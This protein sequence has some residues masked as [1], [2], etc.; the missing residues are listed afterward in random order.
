MSVATTVPTS[1]PDTPR[2]LFA[3]Q[4]IVDRR[5]RLAGYELLY[6]GPRGADGEIPDA[7][8]ATCSVLVGAF[9]EVGFGAAVGRSTAFLNVTERFLREVDPLPLAPESTVL[10]LLEDARPTPELVSRLKALRAQ[11]FRVALD[12][13]APGPASTPLLEVADIVK[14]DLRA[15]PRGD[16]EKLM[17]SLTARGLTV[18]AEKVEDQSEF[19]WSGAAGAQLFQGYFFCKPEIVQ[20][21]EIPTSVSSSLADIAVL[22]RADATFEEIEAIVTRDPG[23]TLRLLRLLNSAAYSLRRRITS[24]HDAVTMLGAR[25]VRQWAMMLV[26]GGV[27]TD[28]DELVPT[29]LSRARTLSRL[30]QL[31]GAD[32]DIAF[33]VGLLSVA[34]AM[35][36]VS[37]ANA[38]DGVPLHE[39]VIDALLHRAGPDG[40]A[41]TAVLAY[42]W[43]VTPGA[44][45]AQDALGECY[46]EALTWSL[47]TASLARSL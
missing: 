31:R 8:H 40:A 21:R 2:V 13:F 39:A 17:G 7:E 43:G 14:V 10:E 42:E 18:V 32:P 38:L 30:A 46:A 22:S 19:E 25:T 34:D 33:S 28:C 15:H 26:L 4:A 35:L 36:G 45:G 6:R 29:A 23:L 16:A 9:A 20:G 3:R 37:M 27:A 11:G 1:S 24:V 44:G 41:L 5:G 12:D 47:Q